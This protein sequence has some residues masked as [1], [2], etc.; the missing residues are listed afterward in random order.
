MLINWVGNGLLLAATALAL[1]A[2]ARL[3][4]RPGSLAQRLSR[5][6]PLVLAGALAT[7]LVLTGAPSYSATGGMMPL[8]ARTA[9]YL[10]FLVGWLALVLAS[11]GWAGRRGLAQSRAVKAWPLTAGIVLWAWLLVSFA[12]DHNVRVTRANAGLGSNNVVL[13]YRDWLSGAAGRYDA[14][15]RARYQLLRA[16]PGRRLCLTPLVAEPPTL[17]YYDIT[18]DS[19]YWGNMSYAQYFGQRAVWIGPGGHAPMP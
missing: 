12:T 6:H 19:N 17:L 15:Q 14:Q 2:L 3:A 9:V 8:R 10:L 1:P 11:V 13:A 18:T 7:L 4:A 5:V 16:A